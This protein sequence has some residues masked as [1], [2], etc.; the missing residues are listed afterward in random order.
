ME[1]PVSSHSANGFE[2]RSLWYLAP[3]K[4]EIRSALLKPLTDGEVRVRALFGAL[5]RGT[6]SLVYRGEIPESEYQRM[7]AP[8]MS[9]TFPF[10]VKYGYCHVGRIE[11]GP[12]DWIGQLVFALRPHE[13]MYVA[14]VQDVVPL[15]SGLTPERAVLSANM[16]TAL[17]AVWDASPGPGDNIVIVGGGVVGC[18][19]AYLCA[20]LKG[21][22]VTLVD[23][24]P[25]RS[26][27][28]STLGVQFA[29]PQKTPMEC[30]VV[31]H[32]SA[33]AAGLA[34]AIGAA[35]E[36]AQVLELSWYGSRDIGL[37]LGGAFHSRQIR[38]QSSQVGHVSASRRPR[39]T[40]RKRLQAAMGMLVDERLDVLLTHSVDFEDLPH[41]L[42]NL[43]GSSSQALCSL[44]RYP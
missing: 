9:G 29:L 38:L 44:I 28:A 26:V 37:S 32:C 21:A 11:D 17:N 8:W 41:H 18:L 34:T 14:D 3:E 42:P 10:P 24:N 33:S 36:E 25:E 35:G 15:P 6:E 12:A 31:F 13:S 27:V 22:N 5:S 30:D 39:W 4:V 40:H 16:E 19:V 1:T 43:L 23:I 7:A 2:A 20:G